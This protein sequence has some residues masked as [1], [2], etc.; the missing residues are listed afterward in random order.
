MAYLAVKSMEMMLRPHCDI[1]HVFERSVIGA[2]TKSGVPNSPPPSTA[3][4]RPPAGVL[5]H[6]QADRFRIFCELPY[7]SI[8]I[9]MMGVR[10]CRIT[11]NMEHTP[12]LASSRIRPP[13]CALLFQNISRTCHVSGR[14][15]RVLFIASESNQNNPVVPPRR[16][17][18]RF[19]A[20]YY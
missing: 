6:V 2:S 4:A 14:V 8:N 19:L 3:I 1:K 5:W 15:T 9:D 16:S 7:F 18:C 10:T 17:V 11:P 12:R 13:S 20:G